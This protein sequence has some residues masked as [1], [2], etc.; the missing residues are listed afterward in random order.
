MMRVLV[1]DLFESDAQTLVNTVNIAGV[2]GKGVALGFR[3]RFRDMYEDYV[4]R[5]Q[6]GLVKLGEPYVYKQLIP[7]WIVN[8]P[9]KEHWR[10]VARLSDIVTGLEYLEEHYEGWGLTSLAV[11]PL[12]CG[13][14][15]LEWRI[16]GPT[17]Y[18]HLARLSI[19]VELYAPHGTPAEQ[20]EEAFLMALRDPEAGGPPL[21]VSPGGVALTE[22]LALIEREPYHWP[23]GRTAFQKI[24]YF[25]TASGIPTGLNYERGS[26]GPFAPELK[27]LT[28]RLVNN[29]V[30]EERRLGRMFA[31][32]PGPTYDDARRAYKD[33]LRSWQQVIDRIADLFLRMKTIDAEAAATVHF[34]A[35]SLKDSLGQTPSESEV[36]AEVMRW[37]QRR[38]PPLDEKQIATTIRNLAAL[39]WL[40][41]KP[42]AEL[43]IDDEVELSV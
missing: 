19:P 28:T 43:P 14:G 26:Y 20:L 37:K 17:L 13:E 5:C 30:V 41:V 18:R 21:R 8:F 23:V 42:S 15:Q 25:A 39:G 27:G 34:A 6:A 38:R 10:S 2:M 11:P 40:E 9:T 24:A 33:H 32:K 16:V 4:A 29:G 1:G 7:P 36:L 22:V 3:R 31:V 35:T 12:G